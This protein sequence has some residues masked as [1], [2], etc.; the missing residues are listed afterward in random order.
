M[1]P[2]QSGFT[3]AEIAIV[4]VA[5]GLLLAGVFK[6]QEMIVQA[7]IKA[8]VAEIGG[9]SAA[10]YAYGERYGELPGDDKNAGRWVGASPGSGNAAIEG[11]YASTTATDES[12][13]LWDH[14]RRAGFING[15]GDQNPLNAVAGKIG[16]QTGDGT[17][18]GVLGAAP[19]T[20]LFRGH[21]VC[22]ANLPDKIA[23]A[24]DAQMDDG[25]GK[26]GSIR[27]KLGG[28]NPPLVSNGSA[29]DYAEGVGV[30]VVCRLL[31]HH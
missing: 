27:A 31:Y 23:L 2:A 29:D 16:V 20:D 13:L 7:R 30:Y 1:R 4:L 6:A 9:A 28:G 12:R 21:L 5:I 15:G 8:V 25:G 26:T 19:G 3:L 10:I 22:S 18:G 24:V 17:G 11:D 14:L